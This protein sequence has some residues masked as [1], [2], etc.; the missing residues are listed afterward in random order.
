MQFVLFPLLDEQG[1]VQNQLIQF[2][3]LF[4]AA[5]FLATMFAALT[6]VFGM[7]FA[8]DVFDHPSS[9]Q[10]IVYLTLIACG[11]VYFG[12]LFYFR[13]KKIFPL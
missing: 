9:F 4:T 12:F 13:Y 10:L 8:D 3:L 7:N 11:L 5:T 6:A 1:N 2:Q